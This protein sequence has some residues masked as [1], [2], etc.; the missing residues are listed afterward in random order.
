MTYGNYV[1]EQYGRLFDGY[2]TR[3]AD[4]VVSQ[5]AWYG[6]VHMQYSTMACNVLI[7]RDWYESTGVRF[8]EGM[9]H[10]DEAWS[11][12]LVPFCNCV[13]YV[14]S[15]TYYYRYRADSIMH[16]QS[17]NLKKVQSKMEILKI[18]RQCANLCPGELKSDY[19]VLHN[20]WIADTLCSLCEISPVESAGLVKQVLKYLW[21]SDMRA[22]RNINMAEL[23]WCY[24]F[25]LFLP[26]VVAYLI[27]CKLVA[28]KIL[29]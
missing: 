26:D 10:E 8:I 9:L 23:R 6:L 13:A 17:M 4:A 24:M 21:V 12:L 3:A 14:N 22:I 5:D 27:A 28:K 1:N 16:S 25:R 29:K 11:L 18:S 20:R 2:R 7:R 15:I 19:S